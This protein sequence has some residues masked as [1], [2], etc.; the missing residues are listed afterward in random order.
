ML[1][2]RGI[3][4][5]RIW[6]DRSAFRPPYL[7]ALSMTNARLLVTGLT[8]HISLEWPADLLPET[9]IID[10]PASWLVL[11]LFLWLLFRRE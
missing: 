1:V 7:Y 6:L 4:A 3:T 8:V 11:L 2:N 10:S 9:L 5:L